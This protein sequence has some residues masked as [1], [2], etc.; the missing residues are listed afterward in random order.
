LSRN[1]R[2]RFGALKSDSTHRFFKNACTKSG[3]LRNMLELLTD[4]IFVMFGGRNFQKSVGI[5]MDTI[6]GLHLDIDSESRLRRKFYDKK[7]MISIFPL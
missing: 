7:R 6:C 1:E 5:P 4:N 3:S 2:G